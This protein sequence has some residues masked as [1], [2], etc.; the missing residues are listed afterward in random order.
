MFLFKA[1]I[2]QHL[3]LK[4]AKRNGIRIITTAET[5]PVG[6]FECSKSYDMIHLGLTGTVGFLFFLSLRSF[7]HHHLEGKE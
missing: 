1:V 7:S 5:S 3:A 2:K 4:V 6:E